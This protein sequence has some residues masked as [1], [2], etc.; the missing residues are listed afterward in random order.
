MPRVRYASTAESDLL[1]L[2]LTIAE[3]NPAAADIAL[4]SI[5]DGVVVVR[6]LHQFS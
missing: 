6:V 1:E 3:D 5:Q 4:D 2:W